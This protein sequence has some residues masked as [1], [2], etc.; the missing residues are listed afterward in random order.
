MPFPSLLFPPYV[1]TKLL[2]LRDARRPRGPHPHKA[3]RSLRHREQ[4][5]PAGDANPSQDRR[6]LT[7]L[8]LGRGE[9]IELYRGDGPTNADTEQARHTCRLGYKPN[10]GQLD[11]DARDLAR[12]CLRG[13]SMCRWRVYSGESSRRILTVTHKGGEAALAQP[14]TAAI[15]KLDKCQSQ[16][17]HRPQSGSR[18]VSSLLIRTSSISGTTGG[19]RSPR[20]GLELARRHNQRP[21]TAPKYR[22]V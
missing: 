20:R 17:R 4:A 6:L 3:E 2:G 12:I 18:R 14:G 16:L 11:A 10:M 19:R 21:A 7:P 15:H 5:E 22:P 9:E 1:S 13:G 8:G